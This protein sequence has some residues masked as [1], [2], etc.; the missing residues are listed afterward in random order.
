MHI[1]DLV[2]NTPLIS[3]DKLIDGQMGVKLL[4]KAE[5]CN[6]SG[7]VKDRAA[8]FMLLDGIQK[9]LLTSG[10]T[11]VDATSGNTGI[12]YAMMG[13]ALGYPVRLYLPENAN[14]ERKTLIRSFAAEI[15]ETSSLEGS[16]GAYLAAKAAVEAD[17]DRYFYPDQ[18][19]N[20]A[21]PLAHY[22]TTGVE[23]WEQT[24]NQV[25]HFI[26]GIGTS[27]TFMGIARRLKDFNPD[28]KI[29][30]VQP[31]TPFHGIEGT[32]HLASTVR[33]GIY[34]EGMADSVVL[35]STEEAY[36]MSRRLARDAGVSVGISSGSNV[37]AAYQLAKALPEGSV[38]VTML[39]DTGSRYLSDSF[40]AEA[41]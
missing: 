27:G 11:I 39:C 1:L 6:P 30:A 17:P 10:K 40:W 12:A 7:S 22:S 33:Q 23:I 20:P 18:Y 26:T 36:A 16:D 31:D 38:V 8:K 2:G 32:R 24:R 13:A 21:N 5:F 37:A 9:G 4:A 35:T 41:A 28:I 15:V 3:L 19:N 14:V 34:E 25:T 29:I